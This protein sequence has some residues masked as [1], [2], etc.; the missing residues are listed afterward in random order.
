[1]HFRSTF[2]L[3]IVRATIIWLFLYMV[4]GLLL[5]FFI[6][7]M[8]A[9]LI[10]LIIVLPLVAPVHLNYYLIDRL[11]LGR[12]YWQYFTL[13]IISLVVF[14]FFAQ[15]LMDMFH[16]R[17]GEYF[18][19]ML[20]PFVAVLITSGIKGFRDHLQS[21]Y[22]VVEARARQAEAE[23]D[24]LKAQVNP[25]FLFNTLNSIYSLSLDQS[26]NTSMAIIRLSRLMRYHLENSK[27]DSV[28]LSDEVD[29][30]ESYIE[31]EKLRFGK[32]CSITFQSSGV[33]KEH[34]IPPLLLLPLVENCFKHGISIEKKKNEIGIRISVEK[35]VLTFEAKNS[36]PPK[37]CHY[38]DDQKEKTGIANIKRRLEILYDAQYEFGTEVRSE[39]FYADLK[40]KL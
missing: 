33:N 9:A 7:A 30:V 37:N 40:I 2:K 22:A 13:L 28:L 4:F 3:G 29:F 36:L 34:Y 31:L 25:H 8:N 15:L 26:E 11:F 6:G 21:N 35:N 17:E 27:R 16:N 19:A 1:M 10:S 20:N 39:M 32:N 38:K 23:L 14:G 24:L 18:G 12:K 5:S